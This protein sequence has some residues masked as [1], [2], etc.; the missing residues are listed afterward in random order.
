MWRIRRMNRTNIL[1]TKT[2]IECL[3]R[4]EEF[5][6]LPVA[7][8]IAFKKFIICGAQKR[9][10]SIKTELLT[11]EEGRFIEEYSAKYMPAISLNLEQVVNA[12]LIHYEQMCQDKNISPQI[13][14]QVSSNTFF[15]LVVRASRI[16]D[17]K[18]ILPIPLN[19]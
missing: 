3:L 8:H 5:A 15:L 2:I 7:I 9:M 10:S 17:L 19:A 14:Q 12:S 13:Y 16:G 18:S 1:K 6:K 4:L 11:A